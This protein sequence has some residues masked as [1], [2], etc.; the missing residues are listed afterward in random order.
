MVNDTS[1]DDT[2]DDDDYDCVFAL[3]S[4]LRFLFLFCLA[5]RYSRLETIW[6]DYYPIRWVYSQLFSSLTVVLSF[7]AGVERLISRINAPMS[8][9]PGVFLYQ[10]PQPLG[11]C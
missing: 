2:S 9:E 3:L 1:D 6:I 5:G 10:V 4:E 11:C 8:H 7:N